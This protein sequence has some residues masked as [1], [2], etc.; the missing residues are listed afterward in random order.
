[1]ILLQWDFPVWEDHINVQI[2]VYGG[3]DLNIGALLE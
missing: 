3:Q 1:M 2:A